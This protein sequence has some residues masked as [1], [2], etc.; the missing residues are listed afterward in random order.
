[1]FAA[2]WYS[3]NIIISSHAHMNKYPNRL[4]LNGISTIVK[5]GH[6]VSRVWPCLPSC[7]PFTNLTSGTAWKLETWLA[8]YFLCLL[9]FF[10]YRIV[11]LCGG[12]SLSEELID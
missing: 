4:E 1:M 8:E 2:K 5:T 12:V 7:A 9:M 6:V 10:A 3:V 11:W